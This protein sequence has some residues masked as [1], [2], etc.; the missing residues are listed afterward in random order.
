M[1]VTC[2]LFFHVTEGPK[3]RSMENID[4][5]EK[6][7]KC[8]KIKKDSK[9]HNSKNNHR[10]DF[11]LA[12]FEREQGRIDGQYQ[13]RTGWQGRK[14]A[15]SHFPTRSPWR[16]NWRTDRRT[17]RRTNRRTDQQRTDGWTKP[18]LECVSATKN[19]IENKNNYIKKI[20]LDFIISLLR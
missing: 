17:D 15:F 9:N 14:C 11:W 3:L 4:I 19:Y 10:R 7:E 13:L 5:L 18:L 12:P 20:I 2:W 8:E 1:C 16:T 6:C